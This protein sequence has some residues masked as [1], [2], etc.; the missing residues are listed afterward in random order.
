MSSPSLDDRVREAE[1]ALEDVSANTRDL[2]I[3]I[4]DRTG[5]GES[6]DAF[7]ATLTDSKGEE[8]LL[9]AEL[10]ILRSQLRRLLRSTAAAPQSSTAL[11]VP[12]DSGLRA[13]FSPH[14]NVPANTSSIPLPG[15]TQAALSLSSKS[16]QSATPGRLTGPSVPA[17]L[18]RPPKR[19]ASPLPM[20]ESQ[21]GEDPTS[22]T[23][24]RARV[25]PPKP[26][27]VRLGALPRQFDSVEIPPHPLISRAPPVCTSERQHQA[28]DER[29]LQPAPQIVT[30]SKSKSNYTAVPA[31]K[32]NPRT[33]TKEQLS[34]LYGREAPA[35]ILGLVPSIFTIP[36]Q[37]DLVCTFL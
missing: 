26:K 20:L 13:P 33:R 36:S 12:G 18:P 21:V 25:V 7:E 37:D 24:P 32:C 11:P 23:T 22:Q 10:I 16:P 19:Q 35:A 3:L 5:R 27:R 30:S 1:L 9:R 6:T 4:A 29:V 31:D 34:D 14:L 17:V 28:T 15:K 8:A 2:T